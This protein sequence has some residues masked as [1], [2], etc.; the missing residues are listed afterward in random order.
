MAFTKGRL[1]HISPLDYSFIM[2]LQ[3]VTSYGLAATGFLLLLLGLISVFDYLE[4]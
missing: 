4:T 1:T 3:L 2:M